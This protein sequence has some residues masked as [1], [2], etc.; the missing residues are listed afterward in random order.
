MRRDGDR[1]SLAANHELADRPP[2]LEPVAQDATRMLTDVLGRGGG[3]LGGHV[4]VAPL[5]ERCARLTLAMGVRF[6]ADLA[7]VRP[8]MTIAELTAALA[9]EESWLSESA[10]WNTRM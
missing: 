9:A 7:T 5:A 3:V 2:R 10:A 8:T 6:V 1:Q 4:D